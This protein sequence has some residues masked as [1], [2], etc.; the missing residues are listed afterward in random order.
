MSAAEKPKPEQIQ[1]NVAAALSRLRGELG[2]SATPAM[3][4]KP[5]TEAPEP[6]LG[7]VISLPA[8]PVRAPEESRGLTA[9]RSFD[10]ARPMEPTLGAAP[11]DM[12]AP[13]AKAPL[14]PK[15]DEPAS[16]GFLAGR[17]IDPARLEAVRGDAARIESN[18][19]E[20]T[21]AA[22]RSMGERPTGEQPDLLAGMEVPPAS[23]PPLG[24]L[25]EDL[26]TNDRRRKRRNRI[27]ASVAVLVIVVGAG[28]IFLHNRGMEGPPP[29][30]TAD[31]SPEKVKPADEGGMQVP[32]QN[33]Q[34][35][36]NL[37][38][39][40]PAATTNSE[41]NATVLPPPEQPVAPPAGEQNTQASAA[42]TAPSVTETPPAPPAPATDQTQAAQ[43]TAPTDQQ[44]AGQSQPGQ[45][46]ADQSQTDQAGAASGIPSVSAPAIPSVSAPA[47]PASNSAT[48]TAPVAQT[49]APEP[50]KAEPATKPAAKP[51]ETQTAAAPA[52]APTTAPKPVSTGSARVQLAAVRSEA[53][54]KTQWAK[55]QKAHP[56]LLGAL[57]L[58]I[59]KVDRSGVTYYRIQAGPLTDKATAKQLCAKLSALK[60]DCIVAR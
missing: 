33:V 55:L 29:V 19:V 24:A 45:S 40:Q 14:E 54:A 11:S 4:P 53:A 47:V 41:S 31:T 7:P 30:I 43:P 17:R 39:G 60:Q 52:T 58:N 56:D 10:P 16:L 38:S 6:K 8:G 46:Q 23:P 15:T 1:A 12:R 5:A 3:A 51:A 21:L 59:Q 36:D 22:E 37:A 20:P 13:D 26:E 27:M 25:D 42:P 49:A 57:S 50:A 34:I 44:Q 35:L 28:W 48:A 9:N 2:S 32:N 18:R